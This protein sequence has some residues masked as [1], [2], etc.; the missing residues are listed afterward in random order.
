MSAA[1]R[2]LTL[3]AIAEL[4]AMSLWFSASAVV[5]QITEQSSLAPGKASWL[6]LTVQLGFVVGALGSA[7]TVRV[8]R[9]LVGP[10]LVN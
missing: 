8:D 1:T 7:A 4:L 10:T 2:S 6:T 9:W 3:L 5:P